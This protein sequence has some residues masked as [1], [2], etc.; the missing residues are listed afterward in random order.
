[1]RRR[2]RIHENPHFCCGLA[3]GHAISNRKYTRT[4]QRY[5]SSM[6]D[7]RLPDGFFLDPD[8]VTLNAW[9][10]IQQWLNLDWEDEHLGLW[11]L[12][13]EPSSAGSAAAK[14]HES[15][16]T[17]TTTNTNTNSSIIPWEWSPSSQ[18]RAVAQFGFRYDYE[19]SVVDQLTP[20]PP[21]PLL[22]RRLLLD[23]L[24]VKDEED[25]PDKSSSSSSSWKQILHQHQEEY[26]FTQ[27]IMN[28]YGSNS[29]SHI[30]WHA[31]DAAFGP[32]ILVYTFGEGRPLFLRRCTSTNPNHHQPQQQQDDGNIN[33]QKDD[34]ATVTRVVPTHGSRYMLSGPARETW[35]HCVPTGTGWRVSITFR[36]ARQGQQETS[37]SSSS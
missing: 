21:I 13:H 37:S 9:H 31:D 3:M 32:V 15:T 27:C 30:P 2:R 18:A 10:E 8:A 1:M 5:T 33:N 16:T 14:Q 28:A 4:R 25:V 6:E 34:S 7:E 20:T 26:P 23:P 24:F 17:T 36:S 35:E 11:S 22:L 19:K 29:Q 12:L